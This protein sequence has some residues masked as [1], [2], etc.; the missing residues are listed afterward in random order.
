MFGWLSKTSSSV[1]S[2]RVSSSKVL[3][4]SCKYIGFKTP[5]T[6]WNTFYLPKFTKHNFEVHGHVV[7]TKTTLKK[8]FGIWLFTKDRFLQ[9]GFLSFGGYGLTC[10]MYSNV[11][12]KTETSPPSKSFFSQFSGVWM[13]IG[14]TNM[15]VYIYIPTSSKVCCLNPKEWCIG[16]P[17]LYSAPFG[18]SRYTFL[19]FSRKWKSIGKGCRVSYHRGDIHREYPPVN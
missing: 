4:C 17:C 10:V 1:V 7:F 15:C 8:Q 2:V 18:R 11:K 6:I 16:T 12:E 9:A 13:R 19:T 5:M 3:P 14:P